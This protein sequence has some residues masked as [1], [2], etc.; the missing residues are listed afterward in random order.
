[1]GSA[2]A[3]GVSSVQWL[4][5]MDVDDGKR[6]IGRSIGRVYVNECAQAVIL[7][8]IAA[9][10]LIAC[11]PILNIPNSIETDEAGLKTVLPE[12]H[13]FDSGPDSSGFSAVLVDDDLGPFVGG[14]EACV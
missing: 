4:G 12:A 8:E 13:G 11:G 7:A 3:A 9:C 10:L 14:A 1:M 2:P 6:R 5:L